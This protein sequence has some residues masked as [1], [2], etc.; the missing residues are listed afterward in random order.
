MKKLENA[1]RAPWELVEHLKSQG[2]CDA[3]LT[4][5]KSSY[6]ELLAKVRENVSRA[7]SGWLVQGGYWADV[8]WSDEDGC[9]IGRLRGTGCNTDSFRGETPAEMQAAFTKAV[10][11]HTAEKASEPT[12]DY[13]A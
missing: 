12:A 6:P 7:M 11:N 3:Y 13:P 5:A 4:V 1:D 10:Q 2:I 9:F 8:T